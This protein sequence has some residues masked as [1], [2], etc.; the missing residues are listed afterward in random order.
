MVTERDV[1]RENRNGQLFFKGSQLSDKDV[2]MLVESAKDLKS[3]V[4]FKMLMDDLVFTI[5]KELK[6]KVDTM[7]ALRANKAQL[8]IIDVMRRKVD[9]ISNRE[10]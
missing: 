10:L 7:E 1:L 3:N 6:T 5:D 9:N 4:F 8:Y 2:R